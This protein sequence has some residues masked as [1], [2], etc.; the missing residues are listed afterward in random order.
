VVT[1]AKMGFR[2]AMVASW[3]T[4]ASE[5]PLGIS[6]AVAKDRAMEPLLR[7]GDEFTVNIL[8]EGNPATR[9]LVKHFLQ[10]F[11]PGA[12]RLEGVES[13]QGE[14]GATRSSPAWMRRT[15]G[16]L[17]LRLSVD[18]S[19]KLTPLQ[20]HTTARS[21]LTTRKASASDHPSVST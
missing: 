6:L 17:L 16:C 1:A 5:E 12:D 3:L 7:V 15:I 11:A 14:N 9:D 8:E 19:R 18:R 20:P 21:A 10:R 13:I 2:H 4:P